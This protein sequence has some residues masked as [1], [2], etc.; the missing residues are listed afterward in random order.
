MNTLLRGFGYEKMGTGN[1][2]GSR[3]AFI[4][5][6]SGHIVRLHRPHPGP[7]LKRYQLDLIEEALR[8]R[9]WIR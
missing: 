2:A 9:G 5:K 8:A 3:T 7:N 4:H 1:T 6:V